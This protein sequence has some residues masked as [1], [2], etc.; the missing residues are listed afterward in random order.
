[1]KLPKL[2]SRDNKAASSNLNKDGEGTR[3][4]NLKA[5][6]IDQNDTSTKIEHHDKDSIYRT[7]ADSING[8]IQLF[9]YTNLYNVSVKC[10]FVGEMGVKNDY[11]I[12]TSSLDT[13]SMKVV[14]PFK[15]KRSKEEAKF[16]KEE[17]LKKELYL[18]GSKDITTKSPNTDVE[19]GLTIGKH[20]FPFKINLSKYG[21]TQLMNSVWFLNGFLTYQLKFEIISD[22]QVIK[23]LC[24]NVIINSVTPTPEEQKAVSFGKHLKDNKDQYKFIVRSNKAVYSHKEILRLSYGLKLLNADLNIMQN[25]NFLLSNIGL[26]ATLYRYIKI[27]KPGFKSGLYN[28]KISQ[29]FTPLILNKH[30]FTKGSIDLKFDTD[31]QF[32]PSINT[33]LFSISYYVE[34]NICFKYINSVKTFNNEV[35][36]LHSFENISNVD[37]DIDPNLL[38][39]KIK[40]DFLEKRGSQ[41]LVQDDLNMII[42]SNFLKPDSFSKR[43]RMKVVVRSFDCDDESNADSDES[44]ENTSSIAVQ[45]FDFYESLVSSVVMGDDQ[46]SLL[47]EEEA[48]EFY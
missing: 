6:F 42:T 9:N 4:S 21:K 5:F 14:V 20:I 37:V 31:S 7:L 30:E 12:F 18:F 43:E 13:E 8:E 24:V 40:E 11:D 41:D 38:A 34:F 35:I 44:D 28:Q 15:W 10:T 19:N 17:F 16:H 47:E 27:D 23:T 1:M 32:M 39:Y 2:F 45:K 26:L 46:N 22:G 36:K 3:T 25:S 48:P 33:K 29:T